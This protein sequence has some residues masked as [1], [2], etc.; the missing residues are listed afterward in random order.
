MRT[1]SLCLQHDDARPSQN[2]TAHKHAAH[3]RCGDIQNF[4]QRQTAQRNSAQPVNSPHKKSAAAG[5]RILLRRDAIV[6]RRS[7]PV[8]ILAHKRLI[9]LMGSALRVTTSASGSMDVSIW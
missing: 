9:L 4:Q 5:A 2:Q 6:F 8:W 1:A 7:R 3:E